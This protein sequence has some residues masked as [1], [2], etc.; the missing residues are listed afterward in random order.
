M[1]FVYAFLFFRLCVRQKSTGT[2]GKKGDSRDM[3][4]R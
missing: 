2:G 1:A 4:E 3:G